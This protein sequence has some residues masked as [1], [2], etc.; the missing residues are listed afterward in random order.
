MD[1]RGTPKPTGKESSDAMKPETVG[2][3]SA[4]LKSKPEIVKRQA[5]EGT[6]FLL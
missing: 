3:P 1:N 2:H 6:I 5:Y 4:S